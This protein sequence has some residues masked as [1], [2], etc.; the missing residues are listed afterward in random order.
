M[1]R[2]DVREYEPR[3]GHR[4]HTINRDADAEH[5]QQL[6]T[7]KQPERRPPPGR[8][9]WQLNRAAETGRADM[10]DFCSHTRSPLDALEAPESTDTSPDGEELAGIRGDRATTRRPLG[11]QEI[12]IRV[13]AEEGRRGRARDVV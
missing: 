1:K 8:A 2:S 7:S 5:R 12:Q 6:C 4:H 13:D 10:M 11:H 9:A 3:S